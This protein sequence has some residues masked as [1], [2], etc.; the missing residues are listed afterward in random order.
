MTHDHITQNQPIEWQCAR[1]SHGPRARPR[2]HVIS[3]GGHGSLTSPLVPWTPQDEQA[4]H[5]TGML[6]GSAGRTHASHSPP[7]S[8]PSAWN[9]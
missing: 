6:M 1:K 4:T 2:P 9:G 3:A 7:F 5:T 8:D